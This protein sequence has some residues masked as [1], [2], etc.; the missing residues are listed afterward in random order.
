MMEWWPSARR[1]YGSERIMEYWESKADDGK[2]NIE[3]Y[4]LKEQ[5]CSYNRVFNPEKCNLRLKNDHIWQ[6]S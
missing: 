6:V 5:Q 3:G 4:E 2:V 1:A